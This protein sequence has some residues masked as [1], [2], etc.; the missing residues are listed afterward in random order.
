MSRR[1]EVVRVFE[2]GFDV[3]A[4]RIAISLARL[5]PSFPMLNM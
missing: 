5:R 4:F 1:T 3:L 2:F